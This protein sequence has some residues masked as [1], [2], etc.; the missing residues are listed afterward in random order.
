MNCPNCGN[1]LVSIRSTR[2]ELDVVDSPSTGSE[3]ELPIHVPISNSE[4]TNGLACENCGYL[5]EW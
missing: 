5:E 4:E 1:T 3:E 2:V